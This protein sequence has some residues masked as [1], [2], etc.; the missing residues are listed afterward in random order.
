M[1]PIK[2]VYAFILYVSDSGLMHNY[3]IITHMEGN[4]R[5]YRLPKGRGLYYHPRVV[6]RTT[7]Q[8]QSIYHDIYV[9]S[10]CHLKLS[11]VFEISV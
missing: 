7:T 1:I 5:I 6:V 8:G 4:I 9:K 2:N 3:I 10:G 11:L